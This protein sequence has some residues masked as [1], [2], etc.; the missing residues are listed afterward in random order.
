M[1]ITYYLNLLFAVMLPMALLIVAGAWWRRSL[2]ESGVRAVRG[3]ISTITINLFAPALLFAA[4]ASAK[5]S[6]ELLSV[7][8]LMTIGIIGGGAGLYLLLYHTVLGRNLAAP[9]R[10]GLLLC[11]MFGNV[12]FMGYPLLHYLYGDQ[13]GR[14]AAFA[15]MGASTPLLWSL[16]V[17]IAVHLGGQVQ[18]PT[19]PVKTWLLLPPVWAFLAGVALSLTGWSM[20]PIIHAAQ[21]IGQPTVPIMLLMLGLSIPWRRLAPNRAILMVVLFKL[22]LLPLLVWLV[23]RYSLGALR[24]A[25]IA[26]VFES[27]VPTMLIAL[28]LADRYQLDVETVALTIAWTTLLFLI[29]LPVWLLVLFK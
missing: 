22:L 28:S 16:G 26:A 21:L 9:S 13:G 25:Q 27:G 24:P 4:A 10:A 20:T 15:D 3:Y 6:T 18:Q 7:P 11:G 12:L 14:Y 19:N 8:M 1:S 5:I 2:G 23:S 17:A 29:T